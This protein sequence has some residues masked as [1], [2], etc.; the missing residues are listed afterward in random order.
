MLHLPYPDVLAGPPRP[1][2]IIRPGGG[3]LAAGVERHVVP[4]A[5]AI[6]LELEAGDTITIANVGMPV[7]CATDNIAD[8]SE[9]AVGGNSDPVGT[10]VHFRTGE[11][12]DIRLFDP[13]E[14]RLMRDT[15][16]A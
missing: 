9:T 7:F 1:S 16:T 2:R 14:A 11:I 10:L 8:I 13:T 5:G 6:L 15:P 4:G 12:C 3:T